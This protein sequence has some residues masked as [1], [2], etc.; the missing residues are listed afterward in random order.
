MGTLKIINFDEAI[1]Y[2]FKWPPWYLKILGYHYKLKVKVSKTPVQE[3]E[4]LAYPV[5]G[6]YIYLKWLCFRYKT[7]KIVED[8]NE[9]DR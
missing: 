2:V 8:K 7:L 5:V 3:G 9:M 6:R 1:E 4:Y